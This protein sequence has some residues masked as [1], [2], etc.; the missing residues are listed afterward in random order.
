MTIKLSKLFTTSPE[1]FISGGCFI[2][3]EPFA[4]SFISGH[5]GYFAQ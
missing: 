1:P 2:L 5:K 3:N 4:T